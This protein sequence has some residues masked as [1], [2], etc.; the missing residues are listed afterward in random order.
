MG[1][2]NGRLKKF[3]Q[4]PT[5]NPKQNAMQKLAANTE[6]HIEL[7]QKNAY[8]FEGNSDG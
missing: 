5:Q 4:L 7:A 8:A 2:N 1:V 3:C 6:L